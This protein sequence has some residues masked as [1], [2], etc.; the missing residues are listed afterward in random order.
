LQGLIKTGQVTLDGEPV[1]DPGAKVRS[2]QAMTV[3]LPPPV[4]AEPQGEDIPLTVVFEDRHLIVIDKPAG[5]VV[6][7]AAGHG[8]GT[9]VN[10]LIGHCGDSLSGIGGVKRPGIVHRLDKDTS[11][12]LVA[13]KTDAAHAGL[14]DQFAAHGA[15]GRLQ[16]AYL[17]L[18][19]GV[20]PRT[21]GLVDAALSRSAQNRIKIAV[22]PEGAG[23]HA[24]THYEVLEVFNDVEGAPVA[25][26]VRLVLETG[27]THQIR[28]HMAHIGHP[29]LGDPVYGRGFQTRAARL[30][31]GA[32]VALDSLGRQALH[33]AELGF[34][35]PVTGKAL[36]FR[37]EAPA[38]F[39]G[40]L[41]AL[42]AA[43]GKP[44]QGKV[45]RGRGRRA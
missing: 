18:V 39:A 13:A 40:L 32:R 1:T 16:R 25:S 35:H 17:A 41:D 5:L 28:V 26:L 7:P 29:L 23:R 4:A 8:S 43:S 33:A 6:H 9:L 34:D 30:G 27:R 19:W 15:D 36:N 3:A 22:V 45:K 21:K 20:P 11:G 42:R 38:D 14:S 10:A 31:D 12:L 37:S 2:G 24:V 44:V